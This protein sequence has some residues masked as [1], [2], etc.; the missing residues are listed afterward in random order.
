MPLDDKL[1][2]ECREVNAAFPAKAGGPLVRRVPPEALRRVV[3]EEG[4]EVLT[5]DA[6]G[7]WK[8]M[9]ARHPFIQ[10]RALNE[11]RVFGGFGEKG[12]GDQ[13]PGRL[14]MV[15]GKWMRRV[16]LGRWEPE[17][18]AKNGAPR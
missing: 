17:M 8:D 6:A 12:R 15:G 11:R 2:Q 3:A 4:P 7:Y 10:A 18:R 1:M 14:R 5:S 16:G 13:H 9:D